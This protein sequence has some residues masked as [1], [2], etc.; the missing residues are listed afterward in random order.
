MPESEADQAKAME[1]WMGWFGS[2]GAAVVDGGNPFSQGRTIE[3]DGSVKLPLLRDHLVREGMVFV[4]LV[5]SLFCSATSDIHS[6][7]GLLSN[8]LR[9]F[10]SA[11]LS[12]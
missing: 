3:A 7:D 6:Q 12:S 2:L 11:R 10:W 4:R 8:Q 9:Q 5:F 1:A